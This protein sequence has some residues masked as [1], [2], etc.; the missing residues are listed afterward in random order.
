MTSPKL[1]SFTRDEAGGGT[2]FALFMFIIMAMILGLSVDATN[3]WRNRTLLTSVADI[4]A[5][6]GVV[7][8]ATGGT[9]AEVR[10]D[11]ARFVER[12]LPPAAWGDLVI[13]DEDV[14]IAGYDAETREIDFDSTERNAVLVRVRRDAARGNPIGTYLLRFAGIMTFEAEAF[15]VAVFDELRV[16]GLSEGMFANGQITLTSQ[17]DVGQGICVHSQDH[18]WLPQRNTFAEGS[19]VSMPDLDDCKNK[20]NGTANPGIAAIENNMQ[21]PNF[22]QEVLDAYAEFQE[23]LSEPAEGEKD[24]KWDTFAGITDVSE[25]R[26]KLIEAGVLE[27]GSP[28]LAVGEVVEL[29]HAEFHS[30]EEL[31]SGLTYQVTCPTNGNGG[32]TQLVFSG[33]TGR[34]NNAAVITNCSLDFDDGSEVVGSTVITVRES[35]SA[36][37]TAGPNVTIGD[38]TRSCVEGDST[39]IMSLGK[40]T[41]PAGF[42]MSNVIIVAGDDVNIASG[43]SSDYVSRGLAIYAEGEIHV[44]AQHSFQA[45]NVDNNIVEPDLDTLRLTL[46]QT[47]TGT[48]L[49]GVSTL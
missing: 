3:A 33:T 49:A 47:Y 24:R 10:A 39:T 45:C 19:L 2:A 25:S 1:T 20:C 41:V 4:G 26:L 11:V 27:S 5:H 31:P 13:E 6:A 44:A 16:C 34:M 15:A 48:A 38:P 21:L 32:G 28:A 36:T 42:A 23:P 40:M 35:S 9:D 30:L 37:I 29:T 8:L 17:T 22:R 43:T 14:I 46:P 7:K 18:V 12:N